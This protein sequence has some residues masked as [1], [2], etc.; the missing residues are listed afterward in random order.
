[1]NTANT[2]LPPASK[3]CGSCPYRC[4][5]ASG[6]WDRREYEKLPEYDLPTSEQPPGV[7]LCHRQDGHACA[8]WVAVHDMEHSLAL[9]LAGSLGTVTDVG[10]FFDY[11]TSTPVWG[12]GTE[13]AEHGMAEIE[14]PGPQ[15]QRLIGRLRTDANR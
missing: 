14:R 15:A 12:S 9:R 2:I 3:P 6:I 7:F 13:A 10:A 5:V 4:D 1:M 11:E 8:G